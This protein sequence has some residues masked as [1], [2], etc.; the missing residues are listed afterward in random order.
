MVKLLKQ[1]DN[2]KVSIGSSP[3][4]HKNNICVRTD[5]KWRHIHV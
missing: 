3:E 4:I 2:R 1:S 5:E